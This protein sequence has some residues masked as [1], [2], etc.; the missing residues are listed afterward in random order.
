MGSLDVGLAWDAGFLPL[1]V[2]V[3]G[4]VVLELAVGEERLGVA[5]K[6]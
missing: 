6:E 2:G 5:G 3:V 1:G 4:E